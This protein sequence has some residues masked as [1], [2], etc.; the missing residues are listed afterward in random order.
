MLRAWRID[1][2]R[3]AARRTLNL[4]RPDFLRRVLVGVGLPVDVHQADR[5]CFGVS[6][7][8]TGLVYRRR[9]VD[10][11]IRTLSLDKGR[12]AL[13][14]K[15]ALSAGSQPSMSLPRAPAGPL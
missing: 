11:G 8:P 3:L 2:Q 12:W 9:F 1:T 6:S 15:R 4:D 5:T 13:P 14:T 7:L 10:L